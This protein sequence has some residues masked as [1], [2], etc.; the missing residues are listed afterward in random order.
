M[1]IAGVAPT[2]VTYSVA[3]DACAKCGAAVAVDQALD[4]ITEVKRSGLEPNLVTYN[5]LI[6]HV[7]EL[8]DPT[9]L[10]KYFSL[11]EKTEFSRIS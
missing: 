10:L 5:S 3:I 11:Y 1:R 2:I 4:L 7:R 6:T 9:L 8:S